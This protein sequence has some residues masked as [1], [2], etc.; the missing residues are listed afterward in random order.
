[1]APPPEGF[2]LVGYLLPAFAIVT[3]GMLV[4]L[5]ARGGTSRSVLAPVDHP[6]DEQSERLRAAMKKLEETESPDW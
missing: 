6:T 2:N 5:V 1:M 3:A 4:G